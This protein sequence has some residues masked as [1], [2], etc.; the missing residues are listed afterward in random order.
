[1][2]RIPIILA[3]YL[4]VLSLWVVACEEKTTDGGGVVPSQDN[5]TGADS[6]PFPTV[7]ND[8]SNP[9]FVYPD[10]SPDSATSN[11]I[12]SDIPPNTTTTSPSTEICS[13]MKVNSTET[14]GV[15]VRSTTN[16]ASEALT[17]LES[18]KVVAVFSEMNGYV[19]IATP[20][21]KGFVSKSF[22]SCTDKEPTIPTST[23]SDNSGAKAYDCPK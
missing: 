19:E 3:S 10:Y 17:T 9:P 20:K 7:S 12:G 23:T 15:E 4:S 5:P 8:A 16:P 6:D 14:L 22:L 18:G 13:Q 11:T 2:K 1:M 21:G